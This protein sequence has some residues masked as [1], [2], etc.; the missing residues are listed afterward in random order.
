MLKSTTVTTYE[1]DDI[2]TGISELADKTLRNIKLGGESF[3]LLLCDSDA[4]HHA[5]ASGL[6]QKLGIPIVGFSTT[7]MFSHSE[8][9]CE[10]A[11]VLTTVTS[12]DVRF[13]I[14]ASEPLTADNIHQQIESTYSKAAS[15]L[16]GEPALVMAFPPYILGITIDI[17]PRELDR[18]SGGAPVFGGLPS[19]DEVHGKTAI[20]CLDTAASDRMVL[21]LISGAIKPVMSVKNSLNALANLKRTVTDAKGSEIYRVGDDTFVNF[22]KCFGLNV[23][24]FVTSRERARFF[25][26]YPL[27]IEH[28]EN[29]DADGVKVVRTLHDINH[30]TGSGIAIGEVPQGSVISVGILQKSDIEIS[31]RNSIEDLIRK[32]KIN[33]DD[34]YKYSTVL[35]ISCVARYYVMA[36]DN[37]IEVDAFRKGMSGD[38]SLSGFYSFGEICPISIRGKTK[39]A[40]HNESLVLLA[41]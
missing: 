3:G 10:S 22:L 1:L 21:L 17:Y 7:A 13:S 29:E 35:A 26:S 15:A 33:E 14:A 11:A 25:T 18:L 36:E 38:I 28:P 8:G 31:T 5:L 30:E 2:Q 24:K 6:R 20:Y 27:L 19:H 39:N 40:V 23:G 37:T 32:M 34:G 41:M 9:L 12:D 16:D 4:D